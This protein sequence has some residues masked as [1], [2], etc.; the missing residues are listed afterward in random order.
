MEEIGT[1]IF[2]GNGRS[3]KLLYRYCRLEMSNSKILKNQFSEL[4]I[5]ASLSKKK[6]KIL[7]IKIIKILILFLH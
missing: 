2:V 4:E 1:L 3:T 5:L 6:K 7:V